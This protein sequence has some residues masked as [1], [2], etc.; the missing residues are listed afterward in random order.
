MP[1]KGQEKATKKSQEKSAREKE[2]MVSVVM[3]HSPHPETMKTG[4]SWVIL[5]TDASPG[6]VGIYLVPRARVSV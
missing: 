3:R 4:S 2:K 1:R 5:A 6:K